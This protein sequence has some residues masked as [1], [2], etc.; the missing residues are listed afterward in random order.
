MVGSTASPVRLI[1]VL[2]HASHGNALGVP[3]WLLVFMLITACSLSWLGLRASWPQPRLAAAADG[4]LLPAWTAAGL[5]V[6]AVAV[7]IVGLVVWALTLTAGL[8]A[9]DVAVE[10][11][12]PFV[13]SLPLL[14]GG[15]LL[16]A[17]V[18]D[19]WR[20]ASPFATLARL[21][22][23]GAGVR[24]DVK[25]APSWASPV[26][27]TSFLWLVLC[28][29]DGG[30]PRAV[31]VWL[32]IYTVSALAG[33]FMWGRRWVSAG[34][35]FAVLFGTVARLAPLVRDGPSGRLRVRAP[36]TGVA[37]AALPRSC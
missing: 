17:V 25:A 2:A 36:L 22:P 11:L 26:M 32:G 37:A 3:E 31:G 14:A 8:F 21:L 1:V 24:A 27:L 4:R 6:L 30:Q 23:E 20:A 18:G 15:M 13:V 9:I 5:R 34:E 35:G 16:A 7:A 28:F 29:H 10:N 33:G 12:A 19:W